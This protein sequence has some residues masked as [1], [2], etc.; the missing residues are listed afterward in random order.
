M[1]DV[2]TAIL[3]NSM[4]TPGS[5]GG[6][7]QGFQVQESC[8]E[9]WI[10]A[11]DE[12]ISS[13]PRY[14]LSLVKTVPNLHTL[15]YRLMWLEA[16]PLSDHP[17]S[18]RSVSTWNRRAGNLLDKARHKS[19]QALWPLSLC[20]YGSTLPTSQGDHRQRVSQHRGERRGDGI[21]VVPRL[22]VFWVW[23]ASRG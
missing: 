1:T 5:C 20:C 17:R 6:A 8:P 16:V 23:L 13:L 21:A 18:P 9:R 11:V 10:Q 15:G 19:Y 4:G 3:T 22:R 12:V 2:N 7:W 14:G